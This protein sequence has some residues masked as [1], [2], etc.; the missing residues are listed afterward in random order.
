LHDTSYLECQSLDL[1]LSDDFEECAIY[2]VIQG[3]FIDPVSKDAG[4]TEVTDKPILFIR[5]NSGQIDLKVMSR[6][7]ILRRQIQEKVLSKQGGASSNDRSTRKT[8]RY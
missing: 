3:R 1:T 5:V 2:D 6:F 7:E 8:S 4:L